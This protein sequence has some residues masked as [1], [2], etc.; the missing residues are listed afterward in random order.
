M[1]SNEHGR[2]ALVSGAVGIGGLDLG[3]RT[4]WK[5]FSSRIIDKQT[6]AH[7]VSAPLPSL[8]ASRSRGCAASGPFMA[9]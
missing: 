1:V 3:V 9:V 8:A 6:N 2:M 4:F 7:I 5:R